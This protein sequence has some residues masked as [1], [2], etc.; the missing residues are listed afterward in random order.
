MKK[1]FSYRGAY[2]WNTLPNEI[3]DIHEQLSA[4]SFKAVLTKHLHRPRDC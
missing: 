4:Y 1:S 3:L 2:A